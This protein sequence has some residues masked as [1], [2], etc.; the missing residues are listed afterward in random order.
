MNYTDPGNMT[1][2]DHLNALCVENGITVIGDDLNHFGVKSSDG[3]TEY[4][5]D[6]AGSPNAHVNTWTCS[7]PAGQHGKTCKHIRAV[8]QM[9]EWAGYGE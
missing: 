2:I 6:F 5:I 1:Q 8:G 7:C 9:L 3:S 4:T